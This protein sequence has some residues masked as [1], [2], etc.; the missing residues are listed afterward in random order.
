[1]TVLAGS[2]DA[3][4]DKVALAVKTCFE[5]QDYTEGRQAFAEKRPA[6]FV[7]R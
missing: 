1:L 7:G 6:R 2:S 5:S 4:V 3:D